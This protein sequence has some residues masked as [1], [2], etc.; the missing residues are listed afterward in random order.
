[1]AETSLQLDVPTMKSGVL[2]RKLGFLKRV[3]GRDAGKLSGCVVLGLCSEVDLLCLVR[4]CKELE[5]SFGTG[6]REMMIAGRS[7]A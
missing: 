6:F 3:M 2:V 5:E 7:A 4:E 1:M